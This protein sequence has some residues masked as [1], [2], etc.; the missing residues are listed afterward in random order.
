VSVTLPA[1]PENKRALEIQGLGL[2]G[3]MNPPGFCGGSELTVADRRQKDPAKRATELH[4]EE[5][6][7]G[8]RNAQPEALMSEYRPEHCNGCLHPDHC[9]T[10]N[11]DLPKSRRVE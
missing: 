2:G 8:H 6:P 1:G 7:G 3:G 11:S 5:L 10:D 4:Y 9:G